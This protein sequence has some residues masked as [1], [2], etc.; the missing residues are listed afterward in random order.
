MAI[1]R[2]DDKK[3]DQTAILR[4]T[5]PKDLLRRIKETKKR[6]KENNLS[7]DIK[8]DVKHAIEKAIKEAED[9]IKDGL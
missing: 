5:I 2:L 9:A 8:P 1:K 6:C 7:F 3:D 4:V